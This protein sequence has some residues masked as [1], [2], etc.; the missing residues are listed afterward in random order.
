ML[1]LLVS[2]T[3]LLLCITL[4][5]QRVAYELICLIDLTTNNKFTKISQTIQKSPDKVLLSHKT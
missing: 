1:G 5:T 2:F 3:Q 4:L